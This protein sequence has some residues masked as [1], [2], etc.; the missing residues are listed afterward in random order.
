MTLEMAILAMILGLVIGWAAGDIWRPGL[1]LL[2]N[3]GIGIVSALLG[4]WLGNLS[5][6][7][8]EGT[9]VALA[10]AVVGALLVLFI[11]NTAGQPHRDDA[12]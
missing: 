11:G 2:L 1:P 6:F 10:P 8:A 12:S 3:L 7:P 4:L 5:G 9:V